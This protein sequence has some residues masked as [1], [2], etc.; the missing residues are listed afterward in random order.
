MHVDKADPL[1]LHDESD[2]IDTKAIA[3]SK[4]DLIIG[5]LSGLTKRQYGTS[6]RIAPTVA[7]QKVAWGD[8]WHKV[9]TRLRLSPSVNPKRGKKRPIVGLEERIIGAPRLTRPSG[10]DWGSHVL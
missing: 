4:P 10:E 9:I 6:S 2:S 5:L 1:K 8:P 7:Y 3:A